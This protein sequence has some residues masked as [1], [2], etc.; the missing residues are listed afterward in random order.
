MTDIRLPFCVHPL[1]GCMT[2]MYY[3]LWLAKKISFIRMMVSPAASIIQFDLKR[4]TVM[5]MEVVG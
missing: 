1:C 2:Y 5:R 3:I 4:A